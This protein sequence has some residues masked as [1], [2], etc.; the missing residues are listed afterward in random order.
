MS[1]LDSSMN[2]GVAVH[3]VASVVTPCEA[4]VTV[5]SDAVAASVVTDWVQR[6]HMR[7]APLPES[8]T[9]ALGRRA[10]AAMA[11]LTVL[12]ALLLRRIEKESMNDLYNGLSAPRS[13]AR[14]PLAPP[15]CLPLF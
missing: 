4:D 12:G 13:N 1:S 15:C 2:A 14:R 3:S 9:L 6:V 5:S 7:G 10:S 11:A 8:R